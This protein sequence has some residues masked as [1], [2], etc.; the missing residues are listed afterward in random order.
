MTLIK[1]KIIRFYYE[2]VD[3]NNERNK[4][5]QLEQGGETIPEVI[6][7]KLWRIKR[8][9]SISK[10]NNHRKYKCTITRQGFDFCSLISK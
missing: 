2:R 6:K 10:P 3:F 4:K 7:R 9:E 8:I 5:I 1:N